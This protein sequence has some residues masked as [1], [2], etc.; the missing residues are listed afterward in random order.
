MRVCCRSVVLLAT[1]ICPFVPG[2]LQVAVGQ[3]RAA[4]PPPA[5]GAAAEPAARP[6]VA[7]EPGYVGIIADDRPAAGGGV[8]IVHVVPNGPADRIGLRVGDQIVALDRI[9]V[10]RIEEVA[11]VLNGKEPGTVLQIA[12][13]RQDGTQEFDV[14]LTPRPPRDER[15]FPQFGRIPESVTTPAPQSEANSG[16]A[17]LL[18]LQIAPLTEADRRQWHLPVSTGVLVVD[19]VAGSPAAVAGL[20]KGAVVLAVNGQAVL[21]LNHLRRFLAAVR[22]DSQVD[23]TYYYRGQTLHAELLLAR[24]ARQ[25][26]PESPSPAPLP[27][28]ASGITVERIER[29]ERRLDL[30]EQ[31]VNQLTP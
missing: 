2:A 23:L 17:D 6:A 24:S 15:L 3:V 22:T 11:Q 16:A 21:S 9:P 8:R 20:P 27:P 26:A 28:P 31:R 30:L 29:L 25:D 13:D 12:V 18:G 5:N 10:Q 14:M 4:E 19:V 7:A 1:V